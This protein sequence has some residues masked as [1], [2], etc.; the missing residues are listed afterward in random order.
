[1]KYK[2]T[3]EIINE[4]DNSFDAADIAG[5]YLRG[6]IHT[7]VTMKCSTRK[8][9]NYLFYKIS[10][11]LMFALFC[12]VIF[13]QTSSP[14]RAQY[15]HSQYDLSASAVTPPLKTTESDEKFAHQWK[16]LSEAIAS[17]TNLD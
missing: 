16:K 17:Q 14:N 1:M 9:K 3:I 8:A 5:E 4:A 12:A 7:G 13:T 2:T 6:N 10:A 15:N 11:A